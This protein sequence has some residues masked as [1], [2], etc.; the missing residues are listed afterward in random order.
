MITCSRHLDLFLNIRDTL[1]VE[2][3][4][5]FLTIVQI[6]NDKNKHDN[7]HLSNYMI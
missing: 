4:F 3:D 1:S 5:I 7:H 2:N 6:F